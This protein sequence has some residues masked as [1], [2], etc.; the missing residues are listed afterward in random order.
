M[1][2]GDVLYRTTLYCIRTYMYCIQYL[3]QDYRRF[4]QESSFCTSKYYNLV[5][6][7]NNCSGE[8]QYYSSPIGPSATALLFLYTRI[9]L[10]VRK[11]Q[12]TIEWAVSNI[13]YETAV[14]LMEVETG[15]LKCL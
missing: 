3:R 6:K 4:N 2:V 9:D 1:G 12:I 11:R 7:S 10:T 8:I 14:A 13:S 15:S 5:R